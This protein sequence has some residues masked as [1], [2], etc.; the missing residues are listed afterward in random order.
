MSTFTVGI[1]VSKKKLDVALYDGQGYQVGTFDNSRQGHKKLHS[2]LKKRAAAGMRVCLEATGRYGEAVAEMMHAQ[3]YAVSVVNPARIKAYGESQLQRNKT[4]REDAKMIAHYGATQNPPLWQPLSSEK[5]EL[6][7]L[8]RRLEAL[9]ADRTR[10]LNR[11]QAG[12]TSAVVLE[13]IDAHIAFLDEQIK[14]VEQRIKEL[15]DNDPDLCQQRELLTSIPGIGDTTATHFMAE[16]PDISRFE[17]AGQLAAYAGL[18]PKI[19]RSG[20]SINRPGRLVKTGNGRLRTAFFLP[21]INAK[22]FNPIARALAERLEKAGKKPMTIVGAVMR[23]L[24]HLAYGVLK[25]RQP[26]DPNYLVN[27]QDSA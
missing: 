4:D 6:Q 26:F 17:S 11:R 21:A 25:H 27:V 3:G 8:A 22:R 16:V 24:I 14:T 19:H 5:R 20:S 13:G 2:W 1:D 23:K 18:T 9:K 12:L 7:D 15:I 10:E